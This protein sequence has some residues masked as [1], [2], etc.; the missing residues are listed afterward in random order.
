MYTEA[1][2]QWDFNASYDVTENLTIFA[3]G[4]NLTN[5]YQ[6]QHGRHERMLINLRQSSPRYNLGM[7]YTF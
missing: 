7:R 3:E 1:Y 2:G 4:I 6:R 5:E